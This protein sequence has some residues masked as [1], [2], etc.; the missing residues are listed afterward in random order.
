MRFVREQGLVDRVEI[1]KKFPFSLWDSKS[2]KNSENRWESIY[3]YFRSLYE[4]PQWT[5]IRLT[6]KVNYYISVL[7]MRFKS[8]IYVR[9]AVI[10]YLTYFRSLYEILF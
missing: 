9:N 2:G 7:S 10:L 8:V 4:I 6:M 5:S 1:L 3:A